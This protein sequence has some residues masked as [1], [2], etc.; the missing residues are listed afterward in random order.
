MWANLISCAAPNFNA[1]ATVRDAFYS[2]PSCF[3][4]FPES[5]LVDERVT[6]KNNDASG[7]LSATAGGATAGGLLGVGSING[8]L[9]GEQVDDRARVVVQGQMA[10]PNFFK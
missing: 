4:F 5:R 6:R 1:N 7:R 9:E 8:L 10:R 2:V 3:P